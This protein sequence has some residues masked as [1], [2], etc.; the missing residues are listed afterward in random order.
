MTSRS[1]PLRL[2]A[3]I[4]MMI[5]QYVMTGAYMNVH[6]WW[7]MSISDR[8]VPPCTGPPELPWN[9]RSK[10]RRRSHRCSKF[11]KFVAESPS[12]PSR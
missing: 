2:P 7:S 5:W 6:M 4:R 10:V 12:R 3:E 1:P 9:I 8:R 11:P